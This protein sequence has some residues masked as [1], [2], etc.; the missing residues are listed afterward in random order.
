MRIRCPDSY[1]L[2]YR[3]SIWL[4][5]KDSNLQRL[6]PSPQGMSTPSIILQIIVQPTKDYQPFIPFVH[7]QFMQASL[8]CLTA[9][10]SVGHW[11]T[12]WP[13]NR[14]LFFQGFPLASLNQT[15]IRACKIGLVTTLMALNLLFTSHPQ[16]IFGCPEPSELQPCY[17]PRFSV[18]VTLR[19]LSSTL[20]PNEAGRHKHNT[21]HH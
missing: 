17:N 4:E 5:E 18:F 19:H 9:C 1:P 3:P 13:H 11:L 10:A 8:C 6:P 14:R 12:L 2:N 21:T 15:G 20:G 7:D 16:L